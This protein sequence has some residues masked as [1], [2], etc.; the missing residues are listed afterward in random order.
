MDLV[1]II[2]I[3][4]GFILVYFAIRAYKRSKYFPMI[5]LAAGFLLITIGDTIIGDTLSFINEES[6][7]FIE[8]I[9]E[10]SGFVLVIIAVLKS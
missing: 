5:Y 1:I 8:E 7:E 3:V 4:L 2:H 10:I 9:V 6:K